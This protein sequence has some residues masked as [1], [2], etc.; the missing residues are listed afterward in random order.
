[1]LLNDIG[2]IEMIE[3]R[4][5]GISSGRIS[6]C[7]WIITSKCNFNC[8]YCNRLQDKDLSFKKIEEYVSFL[9]DLQCK[10]VHLT[11]GEPTARKDL[12]DIVKLLKLNNIRVG[13][14]TNGSRN[15]EY[16]KQL[17]E[18]GVEL[19]SISLDVHTKDLNKK[20]T[21]VENVFDIVVNN[22][23]ELSK[24]TYVGVDIVFND[25]NIYSY[26]EILRFISNLGVTD[27]RIM[28]VAKY[29]KILKFE[30]DQDLLDKHKLLK[31]RIENF[32]SGLNM[33]GSDLSDTSKCHLIKDDLTIFGEDYYPCAVYVR[34]KG[35]PIGKFN[36]N[37]TIERY[38]WF[39]NHDAHKDPICKKFCMDFKCRFNSKV[40]KLFKQKAIDDN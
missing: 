8:P 29:N 26:K 14:S 30:V 40:E 27:I 1:M 25:D 39:E 22:I 36:G 24:L 18:A 7:E 32:N 23:R 4:V 17:F 34:E 20:F 35:K 21:M 5:T 15:L 33:R 2:F 16:Y 9:K 10:Y 13:L 6:Y 28:T 12:I 3:D 37:N 31:F 19:F 38:K 11:G